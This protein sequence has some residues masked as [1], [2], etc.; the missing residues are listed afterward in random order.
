MEGSAQYPLMHDTDLM[1]ASS[2]R[3]KVST[4]GLMRSLVV[5]LLTNEAGITSRC[6]LIQTTSLAVALGDRP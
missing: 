6:H 2:T 1:K 4:M 5:L 3:I